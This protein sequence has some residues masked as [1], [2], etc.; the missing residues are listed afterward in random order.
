MRIQRKYTTRFDVVEWEL[1]SKVSSDKET[2]YYLSV[3]PTE[4]SNIKFTSDTFVVK[5]IC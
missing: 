4:P 3:F 2:K 5:S 1:Q